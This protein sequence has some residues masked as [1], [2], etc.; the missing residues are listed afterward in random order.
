MRARS[1]TENAVILKALKRLMES[2]AASF[3]TG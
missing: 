3:W 2:M 1:N